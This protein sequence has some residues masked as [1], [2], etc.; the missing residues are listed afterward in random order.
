MGFEGKVV[1][2]TGA[3]SGIG[4]AT[5]VAFAGQGAKVVVSDVDDDGGAATVAQITDGGGIATFVHADVSVEDD[6][7]ALTAAA[8][9]G[10]GGLHVA[11]NNAGILGNFVPATDIPVDEFDRIMAVNVR[12]VFL[13]MKHQ[14]RAML[15]GGGGSIVNVGSAAGVLVQPFAAAYSASKHAVAGLTKGFAL[16]HAASGVRINAVCPG[17]VETNIAAHLDL[18]DMGDAP[19]PHPIGRSARSEELAAAIM[20]LASDAASFVVGAN[21]LVDGGLTLKLG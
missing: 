15:A 21:V 8:V 19:N 12:G 9:D 5:A 14:V 20:W 11:V 4:R 6:V 2:V 10:Y 16:D 3:A 7:A 18:P 13:G 17:G 1:I